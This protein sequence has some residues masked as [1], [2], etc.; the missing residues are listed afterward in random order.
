MFLTERIFYTAPDHRTDRPILAAI[1]GTRLTLMIDAGASPAHAGQ[2]LAE[3]HAATA[4][5]PDFVTLTHW[6]WDHTFGLARVGVPSI[7][8]RALT[9]HLEALQGLA[10]DDAALAERVRAGQEVAF[11]AEDLA[12]EYGAE[13]DIRIV[14]PTITFDER[15]TLDLGGITAELF[16]APTD[17]SDD[18]MA[19]Y[20]PEEATLFVSDATGPALYAAA[21]HYTAAKVADLVAFIGRFPALH[22]IESHSMP[23]DPTA[24]WAEN[25]ILVVA[26]ELIGEG[27]T[28]RAELLSALRGRL[29][30]RLP[31]DTEEVIDLFL[32]GEAINNAAAS[33]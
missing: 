17:H 6:H 25:E 1:L 19:V 13:R 11:C 32:A 27:I 29:A 23:A 12:R 5:R 20:I 26:A 18:V 22:I 31:A 9:A 30:D 14:L 28:E 2:F 24:F 3:L 16:H 4:R 10:W 8:Q 33:R 21:P 7:A 15:L